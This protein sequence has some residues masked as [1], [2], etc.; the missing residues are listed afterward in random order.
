MGNQGN[1]RHG[2][3][4]TLACAL[5]AALALY[6]LPSLHEQARAASNDNNVEWS[7]L[8]HD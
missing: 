5:A 1:A 3:K 2:S 4:S 6:A 8:F 7:G